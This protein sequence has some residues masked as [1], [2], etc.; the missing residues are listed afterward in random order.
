[1]FSK[2]LFTTALVFT[3]SKCAIAALREDQLADI[4]AIKQHMVATWLAGGTS[5]DSTAEGLLAVG[6]G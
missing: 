3:L 4:R 5:L 1:M 6:N 2:L